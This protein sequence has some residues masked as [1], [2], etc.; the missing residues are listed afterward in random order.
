MFKGVYDITTKVAS[1]STFNR[2]LLLI[3]PLL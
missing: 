3:V 2:K 1:L